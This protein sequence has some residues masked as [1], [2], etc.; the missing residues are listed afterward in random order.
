MSTDKAYVSIFMVLN[1]YKVGEQI[2]YVLKSGDTL[3]IT[4]KEHCFPLWKFKR[5]EYSYMYNK[6]DI[7]ETIDTVDFNMLM[8]TKQSVTISK[9]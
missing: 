7:Y 2:W 3:L 4:K 8:I 1:E 6:D 9:T 5:G